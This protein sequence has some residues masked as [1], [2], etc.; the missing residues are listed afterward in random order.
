MFAFHAI[1]RACRTVADANSRDRLLEFVERRRCTDDIQSLL[2]DML[3]T[4][5]VK[6]VYR[7]LENLKAIVWALVRIA[8]AR[9]SNLPSF[10]RHLEH[11]EF[12]S[13]IMMSRNEPPSRKL[14][15]FLAAIYKRYC[16]YELIEDSLSWDDLVEMMTV[17][18]VF[19]RD[20]YCK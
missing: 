20:G 14:L 12:V 16:V 7:V 2:N 5:D 9:N 17:L 1:H 3:M 4:F 10:N 15:D 19:F 18:N 13:A 6:L 8:Y 11:I